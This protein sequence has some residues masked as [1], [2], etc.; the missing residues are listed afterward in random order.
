MSDAHQFARD[1]D[2]VR[3]ILLWAEKGGIPSARPD[4]DPVKLAYHCVIMQEAELIVGS[5][6]LTPRPS[7]TGTTYSEISVV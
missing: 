2:L 5:S 4:V 1:M 6:S 3:E 7:R